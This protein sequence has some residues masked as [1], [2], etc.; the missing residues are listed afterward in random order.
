MNN[1]K[2]T[3]R[4]NFKGQ[5]TPVEKNNPTFQRRPNGIRVHIL[6]K[7][8]QRLAKLSRLLQ[9]CGLSKKIFTNWIENVCS[10]LNAAKVEILHEFQGKSTF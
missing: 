8:E 7:E 3:P 4:L 10:E 9:S 1:M 6:E 2:I 5:T